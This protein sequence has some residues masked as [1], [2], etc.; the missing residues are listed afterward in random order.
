MNNPLDAWTARCIGLDGAPLA[1]AALDAYQ[2]RQVRASVAW[3]K[4]HSAF[5]RRHLAGLDA[6]ALRTLADLRRLPFT[7]A[8]DLRRN[9]PPLLSVSQSAVSHVI[10][11]NALETSAT[12]GPA[13]RLFFTDEE[14]EATL[15]FFAQGMRLPARAGDRVLILFPCTRSGS[16]GELLARALVR[17]GATP[18]AHG[19]PSD[20]AAAAELL[21]RVRP[22]VVAGTPVALL[23]L[24]RYEALTR[25]TGKHAAAVRVRSVLASADHAAASLRGALCALWGCEVFEHYGM[26]EMGLGGGVDCPAHAGYHLREDELLVEV[27]DPRSG[28]PVA[29]GAL[30]EV[31]LSTLKR[32]ALPL[33]RYRTGDLSRRLP[34]VCAC[35][36]PLARLER[37]T[38]RVDAPVTLPGSGEITIAG[39]DEALFA[40]P[41]VADFSATLCPAHDTSHATLAVELAAAAPTVDAGRLQAQAGE[42]LLG[43]AQLA[44]ASRAGA[45]RV[46]LSVSPHVGL[47]ARGGK[48]CIDVVAPSPAP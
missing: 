6:D 11:L 44:S 46:N 47:L 18:I 42:A 7:T 5:Y 30:G 21:R 20:I 36:S 29:E 37:I 22:D 31:V 24:A 9:D 10:T 41:G 43:L 34:G 12:S 17:F 27:V 16:V 32:R 48:R 13:K 14:I 35:A 38:H 1:R 2:L 19:W 45:L 28:D 26:T 8:D 39:L 33:V 3:A 23:A 15:D 4:Q 25:T 40:L